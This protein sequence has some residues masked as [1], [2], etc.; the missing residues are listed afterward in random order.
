VSSGFVIG[1]DL[2]TTNTVVA[3]APADGTPVVLPI[4]QLVDEGREAER[5][6]LPSALYAPIEGEAD[7]GF[8]LDE[9]RWLCGE[10][11]RRRAG[12]VPRRGVTSAK[13][14]LSYAQVDRRASILP[15]RLAGD[16]NA[17]GA[18]DDAPRIS[19][20]RAAELV[21][22]QVRWAWDRTHP[23]AK[24]EEQQVVLTVPASFDAVARQLTVE[25]ARAVGLEV[26]LLEEPQAAF[27]DLWRLGG[28]DVLAQVTRDGRGLVLVIDCG[29]GTTDL[30]LIEVRPGAPIE[31]ERV[32]VGRHLLLGGDNMDLALAH[33]CEQQ[34][35][36]A[37][38]LEDRLPERRF[39]GL[40]AAARRAKERLLGDDAPDEA[41]VA[42]ASG[43][44]KLVG[45]TL[46]ATLTRDQ[47]E[48]LALQG[49]FPEVS[50][51]DEPQTGAR[52]GIVA[53]GL[54]YERDVA[55]TR[56]VAAFLRRHADVGSPTAVLLNGGVFR[57]EAIVA[58]IHEVVEAWLERSAA[59]L[60][61]TDPDTSVALGAATYGLALSG[62]GRKITSGAP[63]SFYLGLGGTQKQAVCVLPMGVEEGDVQ[64]VEG[65]YALTVGQKVRFEL[66]AA[67]R[68]DE[69][70]AVVSLDDHDRLAPLV[71]ELRARDD[72][73]RL[74]VALEAELSAIG[75]LDLS[76]VEA[77]PPEGARAKRYA[78]AFDLMAEGVGHEEASAGRRYGKQ[79]VEAQ[80]LI[81]RVFSKRTRKEV[82]PKE[83]KGLQRSLEKIFGKR[84][85]W[86]ASLIRALFDILFR[87]HK[88]RRV[89][90]EHERMFWML[91][92]YCLRPGIGHAKDDDRVS[93]LFRLFD[94]RLAHHGEL[95]SWQQFWICW[96]RV[97][98]GLEEVAQ[99][100]IR[101]A[102]DPFLAP[103]DA[104]LKKPKPFRNDATWEMLELGAGL[105]RVPAARRG[106]LGGWILE[107]TW[108]E[109]DPR[110]W[111]A[112]GRLGGRVPTYGSAHHVVAARTIERWMDHLLRE[113]WGEFP[114][115][116]RAA[117]AMC[118]VTGDRARDVAEA[119]REK[120]NA[121]LAT[122]GV[123]ADRRRPVLE[124]VPLDDADRAAFYGD[125][126]PLGLVSSL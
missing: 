5:P 102:I 34:L 101:D 120:V 119:T 23:E 55:V 123:D 77:H 121:R 110:L 98:A 24:L 89:S 79:L 72:E 2:G 19:P 122:L 29:G 111:A 91:A 28:D 68:R 54:P 92:G 84:G 85:H 12:E 41:A 30:S 59:W 10:H 16:P 26:K 87:H 18:D 99:V 37:G 62:R 103:D 6:Q 94:Q 9:A 31:V 8:A 14:W 93:G 83:V 44:A 22:S 67:D 47:V 15:W 66:H 116:P 65:D 90:A 60:T 80:A 57:A 32:A 46:R 69:A 58:Q 113:D 104:R 33:L 115:A 126:L 42:V 64:R 81:E 75:T 96:R 4:I 76:C 27:Y 117:I 118:R 17:D 74:P 53:F 109:R 82:E 108:M 21:L 70:G 61:L 49:F 25:A 11:A 39:A 1:I 35:Q 13:S 3:V 7:A 45:G 124:L 112:L 36:R 40:V 100:K 125:D 107:R 38:K 56:H 114:T 71:T 86:E 51:A 95:R 106:E 48:R 78:L 88:G 50:A 43:G 63:R 52:A 105:E 97:A 20:V 73:K